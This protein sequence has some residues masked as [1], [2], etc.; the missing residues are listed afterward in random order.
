MFKLTK[1][2]QALEGA[3]G[4]SPSGIALTW[5]TPVQFDPA[6]VGH[7]VARY[8]ELTAQ[9]E[10]VM[11]RIEDDAAV[12]ERE[13]RDCADRLHKLRHTESLKLYPVIARGLSPDPIA[14][15][16]FWQS[17]LV[18]LGLARRVLRRFDELVRDLRT[19]SDVVAS[20]EHVAKALKEY[21]Q[22]NE[23][24]MYPLYNLV[25]QHARKAR[26]AQVA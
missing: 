16:L 3:L 22:R 18:M 25:G 26:T 2:M 9:F 1:A 14:R 17:R 12:A 19:G 21:R 24:E 7:L 8:D 13:V 4:A 20:A 6:L 5:N 11:R 23:T 15:R 10:A